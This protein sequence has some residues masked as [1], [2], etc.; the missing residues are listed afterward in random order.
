MKIEA[1]RRR[2]AE[3]AADAHEMRAVR[4]QRSWISPTTRSN[5]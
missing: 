1:T 4:L 5:Y 2:K 3:A